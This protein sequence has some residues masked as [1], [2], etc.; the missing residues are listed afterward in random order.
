MPVS[1]LEATPAT[2]LDELWFEQHMFNDKI[3]VKVG[4]LAADTEFIISQG[5]E[6]LEDM[7]QLRELNQTETVSPQ[8][9]PHHRR[10]LLATHVSQVVSIEARAPIPDRQGLPAMMCMHHSS[11]AFLT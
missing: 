11:F 5:R 10:K 8:D 4:Q 9:Q 1:S 2:R 3:A 7:G 6:K